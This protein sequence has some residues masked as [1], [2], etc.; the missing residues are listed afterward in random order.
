[1]P[2]TVVRVGPQDHGRHM[3]LDEFDKAEGQEGH[4]YELSR[5]VIIVSDVPSIR[6]LAMVTAIKRQLF[7]YDADHAGKIYT[8]AS[9]SDCKMLLPQWE[10]ERHPDIAV[11]KTPPPEREDVWAVWVPALVIEIVSPGS[12]QRDYEEKREEYLQFGVKE[13]WIVNSESREILI[14]RRSRERWV[15]RLLHAEESYRTRLLPDFEFDPGPV[16]QAADAAG[17]A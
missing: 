9:G 2:K 16:F 14:L 3:S 4:L 15:P 13:Y 10:S 8:I 7:A 12:E 17:S 5:G 6:H 11:Y 1:M